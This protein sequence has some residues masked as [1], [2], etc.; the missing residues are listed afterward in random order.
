MLRS[1]YRGGSS[2]ILL[3]SNDSDYF[4]YYDTNDERKNALINNKDHSVDNHYKLWEK[5]LNIFLGCYA[6]PF[7]EYVSGEEIAEFKTFNICEHK[8]EYI[9]I[10]NGLV[11][12]MKDDDKR[13]YHIYIA[14]LM[15]ERN[16]NTITKEQKQKAQKIHDKGITQELKEWCLS[17]L[18]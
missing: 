17:I 15:F 9:E 6:Y 16:K 13:W 10:V 5:R 4:Y 7:M 2:V 3:N 8:A 18:K 14:C 1:V 12:R 11:G